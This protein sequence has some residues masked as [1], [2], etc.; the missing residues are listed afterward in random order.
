METIC[1]VGLGYAGI[2][3]ATALASKGFNVFGYDRDAAKVDSLNRCQP[4]F[5]EAGV[6]DVLRNCLGRNLHLQADYV[7]QD[8]DV[9]I[10]A[11]AT[12]VDTVTHQPVM[13][14]LLAA[15]A[16]VAGDLRGDPLI[17]VRS[18]V[19]VGTTE[20]YVLPVFRAV[21]PGIR[22]A[23]A[24]ERTIQGQALREI[25]ELP[26]VV[27]GVDAPS[28]ERA[29]K[30]F[31]Q[32]A[33]KVVPVSS[34]AT[35]ELVK[36]LNN[37]HTDVIYSFGNEAAK[38]A[39]AVGVDPHEA[40]RAA[41]LDYPRPKLHSPGYVGG[42]CLSKDPYLLAASAPGVQL[43]LILAARR[44]NENL[45]GYTATRVLDGLAALGIP[46]AGARVGVFGIAFK[47]RPPTDDLRG[48]QALE[49]IPTLRS[50]GLRM[51][52]HDPVVP[53]ERIAA[54]DVEPVNDL[55]ELAGLQ[56]ALFLT[57]A[58][59][60]SRLKTS[61]VL[62]ML[63]RPAVVFDAWRLFTRSKIAAAGVRY[64]SIGI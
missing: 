64:Q 51:L 60:Y 59:C 20:K 61:D 33:R 36:L 17:V 48:S 19:P 25:V 2:T 23:F 24:P 15:A 52:G 9:I 35:A 39:E 18:T 34:A 55:R 22:V 7:P 31:S 21:K 8:Y 4:S 56:A 49:I 6:E 38:I 27:G 53:P 45:P 29:V 37:T 63:V 58:E 62:D 28:L 16:K 54:L 11:V 32:V 14:H 5:H 13:T 44:L 10:F 42:G 30:F 40:L 50:A 26:Q 41:S 12:P 1:V 57:D 43:E 3:L 47:G 46:A